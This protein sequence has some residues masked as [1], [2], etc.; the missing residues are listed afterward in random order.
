MAVWRKLGAI[1]L[2]RLVDD[3]LATQ[4]YETARK[5]DLE[6]S[7]EAE[8]FNV[9]VAAIKAARSRLRYHGQIVLAES[10]AQEELRMKAVRQQASTQSEEGT[11]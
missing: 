4:L 8:R 2:A 11:P 10:D 9:T 7:E 5:E 1:L 3:R 6:P